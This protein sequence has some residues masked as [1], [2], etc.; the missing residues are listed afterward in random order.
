MP[1]ARKASLVTMAALALLGT[2]LA[3]AAAE[4]AGGQDHEDMV[5]IPEGVFTMGGVGPYARRDELPR[6]RVKIDSFYLDTT[7]VTNA[8]FRQFVEATGY[9]TTAERKIDWEELKKGTPPGTPKPP[10]E[11]LEP[12][13]M[14]F[15]EPAEPGPMDYHRWWHWVKGAEWRHPD[16]PGS[17]IEGRDDHPVVHISL[18]DARAFAT[19]AGKRLPTEAEWEYAA[20]GGLDGKPYAW[21]EEEPNE[22]SANIFQGEF[23]IENTEE[24]RFKTTAPVKSFPPN[25]YGLYDMAGNV[26]EWTADC[27]S[28]FTYLE[29]VLR[30]GRGAVSQNPQGPSRCTD[31]EKQASN[32]HVVRGGSFLC[33][34]SYC[35]SYRPSARM[36]L[37]ADTG[38]CHVGFRCAKDKED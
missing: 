6:H 17:S 35:A 27:Y 32:L 18:E 12:G 36:K 1:A 13:S 8:R 21:G 26:W 15:K 4:E 22:R 5:L 7:E 28:P 3:G 23:P 9:V 33:H 10:D 34:P 11:K 25:G 30:D 29:R 38:M 14:V 19:W 16:G 31:P 37:S 20:R 2:G 24:D